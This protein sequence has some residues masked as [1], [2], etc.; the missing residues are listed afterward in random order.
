MNDEKLISKS[1]P[2]EKYDVIVIGG[3]L[4]GLTCA[5]VLAKRG[6]KVI[7]FEQRHKVGGY[8]TSF[9][10][11]APDG[12]VFNF[13][14]SIH[15][16][17]GCK[18]ESP[19][20]HALQEVGAEGDVEFIDLGQNILKMVLPDK[21]IDFS[22]KQDDFIQIMIAQFPEEGENIRKFFK[23]LNKIWSLLPDV[24]AKPLFQEFQM[25]F[26]ELPE[27]MKDYNQSFRSVLSSYFADDRI[28]DILYAPLSYYGLGF[29]DIDFLKYAVSMR[30][31]FREKAYWIKGGSQNL[32][33]AFASAIEIHG[34][35]VRVN[36]LVK[37]IIIEEKKAI[38]VEL[39]DGTK[40]FA[41]F[42]VSNA[43]ATLTFFQMVGAENLP[44]EFVK[45]LSEM[46]ATRSFF[47]VYL[48]LDKT[49]KI[50]NTF[51]STFEVGLLKEYGIHEVSELTGRKGFPIV[52]ITNYTAF[53]PSLA[54][55]GKQII[56]ILA[57]IQIGDLKRDWGVSNY[58]DRNEEYRRKKEAITDELISLVEMVYPGLSE[59]I[60]MKEAATPLTYQ[61]YTLNKNGCYGGFDIEY[62]RLPQRTPVEGLYL[63][64]A[65][66]E[67]HGGVLGVII[68]GKQA[69]EKVHEQINSAKTK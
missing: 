58:N 41:D 11:E 62:R 16:I 7:L 59:H 28:C 2:N 10:R 53:D 69:A 12:D 9:Q 43:D 24:E 26:S 68:S 27:F 29:S 37:E 23:D 55:N 18:D 21:T 20:T 67:P 30:G 36:A 25:D 46:T 65:W 61:R 32:S 50:P 15:T 22:C 48:G 54:Q 66:T 42:I 47:E 64:G 57:P 3:G 40:F 6:H 56:T 63:A 13:E 4:G 44:D 35:R 14:A 31:I 60:L 5:A 39:E 52:G 51:S 45:N 8:A 17:T 1:D 38:G 19:I 49:F 33:N 34:G